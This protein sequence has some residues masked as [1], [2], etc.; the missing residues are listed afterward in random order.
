[1]KKNL[2][3]NMEFQT[4]LPPRSNLS[5]H[6][7]NCSKMKMNHTLIIIYRTVRSSTTFTNLRNQEKI[8]TMD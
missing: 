1:M 6:P 8:V 5:F 2:V 4:F 3:L 7:R